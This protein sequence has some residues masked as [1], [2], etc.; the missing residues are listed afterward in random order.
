MRDGEIV[1]AARAVRERLGDL[2]SEEARGVEERLS[3]LLANA[4]VDVDAVIELLGQWDETRAA[5]REELARAGSVSRDA[6]PGYAAVA[7][8]GDPAAPIIHRCALCGF[9]YPVFEI[10]EPVPESCPEGHGPLVRAE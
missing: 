4:V 5:M 10:G 6:I 7:G 9:A 2:L 3:A 1:V 8:F